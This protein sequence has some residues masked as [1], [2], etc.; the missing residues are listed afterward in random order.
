MMGSPM[1][2]L[3]D[4]PLR[5]TD[6]GASAIESPAGVPEADPE[7]F[8]HNVAFRGVSM[9]GVISRLQDIGRLWNSLFPGLGRLIQGDN[10]EAEKEVTPG[11]GA[12]GPEH[13]SPPS[14]TPSRPSSQMT[15]FAVLAVLA[16]GAAFIIWRSR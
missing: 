3:L 12:P 5:V 1:V 7:L 13:Q 16:T 4:M 2:P 8:S 6:D 11:E 10:G 9:G 14:D 15:D